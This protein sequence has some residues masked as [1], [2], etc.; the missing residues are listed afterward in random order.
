MNTNQAIP[1]ASFPSAVRGTCG[2]Q[3]VPAGLADPMQGLQMV[4]NRSAPR[5]RPASCTDDQ[6]VPEAKRLR[7]SEGA[8]V[9]GHCSCQP[10]D[11]QR[12]AAAVAREPAVDM[13]ELL[14]RFQSGTEHV[15]AHV[16][17]G[18]RRVALLAQLYDCCRRLAPGDP[19][20][21][22]FTEIALARTSA[23]SG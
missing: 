3:Q 21:R 17:S 5:V 19:L 1:S 13:M 6:R 9:A 20:G 18:D 22:V 10:V 8:F 12:L 11:A 4:A 16:A 7:L 2:E 23:T 14:A 15:S